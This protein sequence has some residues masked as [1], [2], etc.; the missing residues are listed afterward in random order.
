[1]AV[2][3]NLGEKLE[4]GG[5][6]Y[7]VLNDLVDVNAV[8]G[9]V[10]F[11]T[12]DGPDVVFEEERQSDGTIANINTGEIRAIKLQVSYA[13]QQVAGTL[14]VVD[15][16]ESAIE[17]LSLKIGDLIELLDPVI[18]I[19][20]I[21]GRDHYKIFAAG[22]KRKEAQEPKQDQKKEEVKNQAQNNQK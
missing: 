18:T 1:M 12:V 13:G 4:I 6:S 19:S 22:I 11:I 16:P 17:E 10:K 20:S 15:M 5:K 21:D 9:D 7:R 2:G 8:L 3:L 14:S